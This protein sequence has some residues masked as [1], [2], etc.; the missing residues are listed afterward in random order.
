MGVL[1]LG[2]DR[3]QEHARSAT[4]SRPHGDAAAEAAARE[5]E[6][7]VDQLRHAPGVLLIRAAMR[8]PGVARSLAAS[9]GRG[10][11][12][13]ERVAQVVAEHG[14]ELLTQL[15]ASRSSSSASCARRA[16][17]SFSSCRPISCANSVK[18][19]TMRGSASFAGRESIAH[20][21]PKY[22]PSER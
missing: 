12:R 9:S 8:R 7:V 1:E 3:A 18:V 15:A 17:L 5:V 4:R 19:A 14:N 21:L 22:S 6:D 11:D 2:D 13:G 20:R 10:D 16:V